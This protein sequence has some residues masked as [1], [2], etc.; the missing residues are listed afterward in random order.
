MRFP[1]ITLP[2]A[3]FALFV[4]PAVGQSPN[5]NINGLVL[6]PSSQLIVGAEIIAVNDVTGVHYTTKT[7]NEGIYVLP[8]LPPGP[9]RVQVSKVGFKTIIKPDIVL[10]VQDALSINFTLPVG[11]LLETVT[12]TGGAPLINTESAA[13]STV[14]DRQ[15][16][17]NLPMNG[18]SFQTLINLVPGVV[19]VPTGPADAGQFSVNGQRA[20]ANYWTVDGVSAN[21]GI[22][23]TNI[24]GNGLGGA[25]GTFSAF[26]GTNSLVSVDAMQ[27]FRI[28]TS[29]YAP[30]FGRS[31]GAQISIVTR[32]GVNQFHGTAFNYLRNDILDAND[33][34]ADYAQLAK[35]KERQNDFGGTFSGPILRDRTFFFF[36]YEG[37]RLRLPQVA[38]DTVPD[39]SA[40]QAANSSIQPYLNA[41]PFDPRQP[42][43]GGGIA[44]YN[45]SYS[46]AATLDAFSLRLDHRLNNKWA[47]SGR[48]NY[49]PSKIIDRGANDGPL[50]VVAPTGISIQTLTLGAAT[51]FSPVLANDFHFNFSRTDASSTSNVDNFGGAV[52]LPS[53]PFPNPFTV[54]NSSFLFGLYALKGG[55][56]LMAGRQQQN[57]QRQFNLVDAVLAQVGRHSLKFGTDFRRLSPSV[58][59]PSY[60]QNPNFLDM[61][62]VETGNPAFSFIESNVSATFLFRNLGVYGQ[63][64]W[65]VT[66]RLTLTYGLRWDVDFSP[67]TSKGPNLAAVTG[68]NLASLSALALAPPGTRSF[69]T[70]FANV[71]PRLGLAYQLRAVS[72]WETVLRGGLG[73]FYDLASA[74]VGTAVVNSN[75]PFGSF[76]FLSGG[77]FPFDSASAAPAAIS[78][79]NLTPSGGDTLHAFD[80]HLRLPYTLEWNAAVEQELGREQSLSI[81]YV[82]SAGRRLLQSS[83]VFSPNPNLNAADLVGNTAKSDYDALQLRFQRR[84]SP[85]LQTL[86][87]YAWAHSI[88]NAS[89]GS[90][91]AGSNINVPALGGNANRG[92]SDF[93]VRH[94]F[95]LGLTY[96]VPTPK[97]RPLKLILQGWSVQSFVVAYS[98]PPVELSYNLLADTLFK[99]AADVRPDLVPGQPIYLHGSACVAVLGPPCAGGLG[100][101]PAAFT[102]PPLDPSTGNPLRQGDLGRNALRG[103]GVAQWDFAMHREFPIHERLKLQF[104]AEL[105]NVLNHPNFGQPVGALGGPQSLNPQFGQSQAILAQSLSGAQYA[106]SVGNGSLSS[107]YQMGAPRSV[108]FALKLTF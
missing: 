69:S 72:G 10:N 63:D 96:D 95:S 55:Q 85:G 64:T 54:Q 22:S 81:S 73:I 32:S 58:N 8:N 13:V 75:Y 78:P 90:S 31:P 39:L 46:N 108:Q 61:P 41:F 86:A 56:Q 67:S 42:D 49:S 62:S 82:G 74:A 57:V 65:R 18:R 20:S 6:D 107:L 51:T 84:V 97:L 34:F 37:L 16:A 24:P 21:V 71:A 4:I 44:Q 3:C 105:F 11:A 28:Q 102:P 92:P 19:V 7:N 77:S 45:A 14:V 26:G 47:L 29:T 68:Y 17:E 104:R 1:R 79:T 99:S 36:S 91:F 94:A 59:P 83:F 101:N 50:S 40:R 33:W 38:L 30:E 48:Y 12:I 27:E 9:Y 43:L 89:S 53:F 76:K 23:A 93:D 25:L 106:G 103:F 35:P 2:L 52:P 5:G 80:P 70:E 87:S 15:F 66:P 88:D 60:L 98:A 100:F